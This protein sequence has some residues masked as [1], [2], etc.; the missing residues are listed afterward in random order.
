MDWAFKY[1]ETHSL[2][3]EADYPY[4]ARNGTC[5]AVA[6]KGKVEVKTYADV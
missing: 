3:T 1:A 6:S 5:K 4:S 2:E